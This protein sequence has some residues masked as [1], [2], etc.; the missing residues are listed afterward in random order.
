MKIIHNKILPITGFKAINL[1]GIISCK[2]SVGVNVRP[3]RTK[4]IPNKLMALNPFIGN[5]LLCIIFMIYIPIF[6]GVVIIDDCKVNNTF[7]I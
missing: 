4:M 7:F 6:D 2:A 3:F 5:I 1:F